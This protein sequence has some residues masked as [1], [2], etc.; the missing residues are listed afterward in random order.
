MQ[1]ILLCVVAIIFGI[2]YL[3]TNRRVNEKD[4]S[5]KRLLAAAIRAA[6]I[7]GAEVVAVHDQIKFK[8]ESKG[9][10]KEGNAIFIQLVFNI[11]YNILHTTVFFPCI[12]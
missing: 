9:Q 7:G 12:I 1:R 8:I 5:L 6:E 11:Q 10:T 4:V 2:A 3:C